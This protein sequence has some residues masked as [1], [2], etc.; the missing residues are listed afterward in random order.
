MQEGEKQEEP[1]KGQSEKATSWEHCSGRNESH[2]QSR[3]R[4]E[5][6]ARWAELRRQKDEIRNRPPFQ[7]KSDEIRRVDRTI[8]HLRL[9]LRA[10][11]R[12]ARP[13]GQER[14]FSS[15]HSLTDRRGIDRPFVTSNAAQGRC[16]HRMMR[17]KR[18]LRDSQWQP[19]MRRNHC[20][21]IA[22]LSRT[23]IQPSWPANS[24]SLWRG[25]F[26]SRESRSRRAHKSRHQ[27]HPRWFH[28]VSVP[29]A[30]ASFSRGPTMIA[31][32]LIA[33]RSVLLVVL[34]WE[35]PQPI[36]VAAG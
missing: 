18:Q 26:A 13:P 36:S 33:P 25:R 14:L 23:Q 30:T 35:R 8:K 31:L 6:E 17:T 5:F 24:R 29:P 1:K 16:A 10:A 2:R 27:G 32:S 7:G 22:S 3:N 19:G 21:P 34:R 9:W 15:E 28:V 4:A 20:L 12:N 11:G